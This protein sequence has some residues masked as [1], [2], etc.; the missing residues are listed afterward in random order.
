[1]KTQDFCVKMVV[2]SFENTNIAQLF[3]EKLF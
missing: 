3:K 2:F 1:M